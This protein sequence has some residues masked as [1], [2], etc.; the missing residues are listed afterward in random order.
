MVSEFKKMK[1]GELKA[2]LKSRGLDTKGNK[3]ELLARLEEDELLN[4]EKKEEN[5][6]I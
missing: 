2:E 6:T 1:V 5:K 4:A 3:T